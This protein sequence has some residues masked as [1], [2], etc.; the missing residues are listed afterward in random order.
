VRALTES[1]FLGQV[2]SAVADILR[3]WQHQVIV[4]TEEI[5]GIGVPIA[6]RTAA[7]S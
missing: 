5:Y 6:L 1:E 4:L 7:G 2:D 3:D